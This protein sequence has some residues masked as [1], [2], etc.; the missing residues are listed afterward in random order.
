MRFGYTSAL[1]FLYNFVIADIWFYI[2]ISIV[3]A[4]IAA[5]FYKVHSRETAI[6]EKAMLR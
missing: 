2:I 6:Q 3:Y 1:T 5:G 4:T